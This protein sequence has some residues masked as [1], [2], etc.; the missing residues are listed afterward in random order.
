MFTAAC[1]C[2]HVNHSGDLLP[3]WLMKDSW[4]PRKL[5]PGL[6]MMYSK[7]SVFSTST[8]KSEPGSVTVSGLASSVEW[9]GLGGQTL[10]RLL[11]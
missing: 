3:P 11:G 2:V 8:M 4:R 1:S 5:E 10:G 9:I 7:S 6:E